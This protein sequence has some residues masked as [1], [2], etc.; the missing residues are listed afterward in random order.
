MK[1]SNIGLFILAFL[2]TSLL[3]QPDRISVNFGIDYIDHVND[4]DWSS[5]FLDT[6]YEESSFQIGTPS[7]S[8]G[9]QGGNSWRHQLDMLPFYYEKHNELEEISF[10]TVQQIIKGGELISMNNFFQYSFSWHG[11]LPGKRMPG[12]FLGGGLTYRGSF[13]AYKPYVSNIF[14]GT[15]LDLSLNPTLLAGLEFSL[16]EK[17]FMNVYLPFE[18]LEFTYTRLHF[19]NPNLSQDAQTTSTFNMEALN[20]WNARIGFGVKL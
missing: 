10:G 9:W 1:K 4:A 6:E 7:V 2:S 13:E 16:G 20:R 19:D 17:F 14:S 3:A 18:L 12:Y 8:L 5:M 15:E 11:K